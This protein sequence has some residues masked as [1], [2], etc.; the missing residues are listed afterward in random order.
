VGSGDEL[1]LRALP[2]FQ[3]Q[4]RNFVRLDRK[5]NVPGILANHIA[6]RLGAF[7]CAD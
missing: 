2:L 5:A 4:Q 1:T 7:V 3:R 6:L